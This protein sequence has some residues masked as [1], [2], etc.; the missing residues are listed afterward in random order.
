MVSIIRRQHR[1]GPWSTLWVDQGSGPHVGVWGMVKRAIGPC[2]G[3]HDPVNASHLNDVAASQ[4]L[5][6]S[7][8][9]HMADMVDLV[10]S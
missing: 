4:E 5:T 6:W 10:K 7:T 8:W 1:Q 3:P 2:S 9:A